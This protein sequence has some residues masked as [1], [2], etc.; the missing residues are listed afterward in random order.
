MTDTKT[1][2]YHNVEAVRALGMFIVMLF[3]FAVCMD[4]GYYQ[5]KRFDTQSSLNLALMTG[6]EALPNTHRATT[7]TMSIANSLGMNLQ[8][9][10]VSYDTNKRWLEIDKS[11][12][13]ETMYLKY[14]GISRIPINIHIFD[15]KPGV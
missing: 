13:Y 12:S 5:A 9:W 7:L 3:V 10:E 4:V 14:I 2:E 6:V 11:S 8:P 15:F 1:R